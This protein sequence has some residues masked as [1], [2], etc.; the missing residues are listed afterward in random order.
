MAEI[1]K[2]FLKRI[3]ILTILL[4]GNKWSQQE[5]INEMNRLVCAW[6]E[7]TYPKSENDYKFYKKKVFTSDGGI[8]DAMMSHTLGI[9][10]NEK[11]TLKYSVT[12]TK[13]EDGNLH[14][15]RENPIILF[16]VFREFYNPKFPLDLKSSLGSLLIRSPYAKKI[17][18]MDLI[19]FIEY[20]AHITFEE[21]EKEVLLNIFKIS[22]SALFYMFTEL[23]NLQYTMIEEENTT[24]DISKYMQNIKKIFILQLQIKLGI[25]I[26]MDNNYLSGKYGLHY[27]I[28]TIF[29]DPYEIQKEIIDS[30]SILSQHI[31]DNCIKTINK[32]M[33]VYEWSDG[34]S[35]KSDEIIDTFYFHG[36]RDEE[37]TEKTY[38]KKYSP[39]IK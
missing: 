30:Q 17:I 35:Y 18:N 23:P 19:E 3:F 6:N 14:W 12:K 33:D 24:E 34:E 39:T 21:K 9:L 16:K 2:E 32:A 25:D 15:L 26:S 37:Q 38:K 29:K 7:F 27:E 1:G 31:D 22:P 8:T 4:D 28:N 20:Y 13:R 5:I 10:N 11:I 36:E